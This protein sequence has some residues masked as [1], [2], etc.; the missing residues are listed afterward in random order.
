MP[1]P[2]SPRA[3]RAQAPSRLACG[4]ARHRVP[5]AR[6]RSRARARGP[7]PSAPSNRRRLV[8][9]REVDQRPRRRGDRE[10]VAQTGR[11]AGRA[12]RRDGPRPRRA[13]GRCARR[14]VTSTAAGGVGARPQSRG[15]RSVAE[16]RVAPGVQQRRELGAE[17]LERARGRRRNT[18]RQDAMERAAL[19]GGA[20]GASRSSP[21][22]AQLRARAPAL[23]GRRPLPR[24]PGPRSRD[25]QNV[26]NPHRPL[27]T[28]AIAC[29]A[30][31][32]R[33]TTA[34]RRGLPR[35]AAA[36]GST[37]RATRPSDRP[38]DTLTA[39]RGRRFCTSSFH[40]RREAAQIRATKRY[41]QGQP[42]PLRPRR[43]P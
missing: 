43:Q 25:L 33:Q 11:R 31:E 16:H 36:S 10:P 28:S 26:A 1:G 30:R 8:A 22:R 13:T 35:N 18:P 9:G 6:G 34:E 24:S 39:P 38:R 41:S 4:A 40:S 20:D 29:S 32:M 2:V 42:R 17:R 27:A 7:R 37:R 3:T 5:R 14:A 19:A 21:T 23:A 12:R 15:R